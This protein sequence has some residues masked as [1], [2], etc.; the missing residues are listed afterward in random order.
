[1]A[2]SVRWLVTLTVAV[3][4]VSG[5]AASSEPA[6]A[7]P[8]AVPSAARIVD[9][10]CSDF[11]TQASAQYFFL[12]A[13]GP[14]SDPHQLD[15]DGDG[16]ACETLPCPCYTGTTGPTSPTPTLVP[17]P[18]PTPIPTPTPTPAPAPTPSPALSKAIIRVVKV[19]D[20]QL[21]K[22]RE[23]KKAPVIVHLLGVTIP[24]RAC[25]AKAAVRDLRSWVKPGLVVKAYSDKKAPDRDS[26]GRLRRALERVKGGYDIGGSQIDTGFAEVDRSIRFGLKATYLRWEAK[27]IAKAKGYHGSC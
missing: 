8:T 20:G 19:I 4:I 23:G 10:D 7:Q 11:S 12:S 26:D 2:R 13:G 27:A 1:M 25:E 22:V 17:T 14:Y 5:L 6:T 3:V 16:I 24:K 15:S 9:R 18:T 21:V